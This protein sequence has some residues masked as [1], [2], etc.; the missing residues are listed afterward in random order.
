MNNAVNDPYVVIVFVDHLIKGLALIWL[1][2]MIV[3]SIL[4]YKNEQRKK[5][6]FSNLA[7]Q[8][9]LLKYMLDKPYKDV[10]KFLAHKGEEK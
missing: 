2:I 6:V 10:R 8:V 3:V 1:I 5:E 4:Q 9:D 7:H